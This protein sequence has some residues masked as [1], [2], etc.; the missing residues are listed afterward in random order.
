[1]LTP[2]AITESIVNHKIK[3]YVLLKV[4]GGGSPYIENVVGVTSSIVV[5][6]KFGS[7]KNCEFEEFILNDEKLIEK[8]V[9]K[10]EK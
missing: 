6:S 8:L 10:N 1:M 7:K 4:E 2:S 5:A 9:N 3:V